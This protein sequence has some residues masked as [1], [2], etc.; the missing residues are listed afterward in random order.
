MEVGGMVSLD[1]EEISAGI[2]F[3]WLG[4]RLGSL[5]EGPL[6][7][8]FFERHGKPF[9]CLRITERIEFPKREPRGYKRMEGA[10]YFRSGIASSP[11]VQRGARGKRQLQLAA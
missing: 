3:R 6:S 2:G 8:V 11:V 4:F 7:G 5:S 9:S 1:A 10:S